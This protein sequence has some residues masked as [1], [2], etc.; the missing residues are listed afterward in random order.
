M[1]LIFANYIT[2]CLALKMHEKAVQ[3]QSSARLFYSAIH[4]FIGKQ[5]QISNATPTL[6]LIYLI[7]S[8]LGYLYPRITYNQE[9]QE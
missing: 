9:H 2:Y 6:H 8:D 5:D 4:K 7:G 3:C 1:E